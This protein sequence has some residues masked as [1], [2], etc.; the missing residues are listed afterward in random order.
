MPALPSAIPVVTPSKTV[1]SLL[2]RAMRIQGVLGK[3]EEPDA[4]DLDVYLE[5][6]ND[7]LDSW[8]TERLFVHKIVR[9]V[10]ALTAG[11][12]DYTIGVGGDF[13]AARP[14]KIERA[15]L[16][17]ANTSPGYEIPLEVFTNQRW[18]D[19]VV[20]EQDGTPCGVWDDGGFPLRTLHVSPVPTAGDSLAL[21]T[22]AQLPQTA[23]TNVNE[24][25]DLPPGYR[26]AIVY[27]LAV[28]M[29]AE[30]GKPL[31]EEIAAVA[32]RA[33]ANIKAL[34]LE[35]ITVKCDVALLNGPAYFNIKTGGY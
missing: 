25:L 20:K 16:I 31:R 28:E 22:W 17:L 32:I 34:N 24:V 30:D 6:L 7:M 4:E 27:G 18:A 2:E 11:D 26:R 15:G 23:L 35:P 13:N 33:K 19:V 1:K 9:T 10:Y 5:A 12:D 29:A 14:T 3:G 8:N 21:Y